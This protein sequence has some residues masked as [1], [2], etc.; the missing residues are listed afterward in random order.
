MPLVLNKNEFLLLEDFSEYNRFP[1]I[2]PIDDR[3][4][5]NERFSIIIDH[6]NN[7]SVGHT[8]WVTNIKDILFTYGFGYV[9]ESQM[10]RNEK[11]FLNRLIQ[12]MKDHFLIEWKDGIL[13]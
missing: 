3:L 6:R 13:R 11:G 5:V 2:Q 7:T 12:R 1:K 8:N 4:H 9:R 10:I